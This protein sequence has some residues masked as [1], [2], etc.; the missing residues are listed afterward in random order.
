MISWKESADYPCKFNGK[1]AL[2]KGRKLCHWRHTVHSECQRFP[3]EL[4]ENS[5]IIM[6]A[7]SNLCHGTGIRH[8]IGRSN[9]LFK[10]PDCARGLSNVLATCLQCTATQESRFS[11]LGAQY[12]TSCL[13]ILPRHLVFRRGILNTAR[14]QRKTLICSL[15]RHHR[16]S[17]MWDV[18]CGTMRNDLS[19]KRTRT[20]TTG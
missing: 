20:A 17:R 18:G 13:H 15:H 4:G 12:A 5:S 6:K 19:G 11:H 7:S 16:R 1:H 10:N 2:L 9:Q 14:H 8:G 3:W